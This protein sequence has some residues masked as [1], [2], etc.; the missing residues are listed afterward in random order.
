MAKRVIKIFDAAFPEQDLEEL[1]NSL[2]VTKGYV[3]RALQ[4]EEQWQKALSMAANYQALSEMIDAGEKRVK[5]L[6][7]S[8]RVDDHLV[9]P[10]PSPTC[11]P[12]ASPS[13]P[14]SPATQECHVELAPLKETVV[15]VEDGK[16]V[17]SSDPKHPVGSEVYFTSDEESDDE[18]E[19]LPPSQPEPPSLPA[20]Q[21][22]LCPNAPKK[23]KTFKKQRLAK[24]DD[25]VIGTE[26]LSATPMG[27]KEV[28][29]G[30]KSSKI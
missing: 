14:V 12:L 19:T 29:G 23:G 9:S 27:P 15:I 26:V 30:K 28:K 4:T 8:I 25:D 11:S 16:V 21:T 13:G 6:Y 24:W 18:T 7:D 20:T 22:R 5:E 2:C 1:R 10:P 17:K 3:E